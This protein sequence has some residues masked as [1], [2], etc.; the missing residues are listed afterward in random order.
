MALQTKRYDI[1]G[2]PVD[3][4][5]VGDVLDEMGTSQYFCRLAVGH[6]EYLN[7]RGCMRTM[8]RGQLAQNWLVVSY[9]R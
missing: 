1:F 6:C 3:D 9:D 8:T 7:S 2:I 5:T 4:V